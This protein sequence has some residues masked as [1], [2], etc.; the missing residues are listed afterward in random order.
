MELNNI[1]H[2]KP[3]D[4]LD[5]KPDIFIAASGYESR[6]ICIPK[7]FQHLECKKIAFGFDEHLRDLS[8]QDND[9]Y[10]K[11]NGYSLIIQKTHSTPDF[12]K[13]FDEYKQEKIHLLIDISVMTKDW[14]HGLLKYLHKYLRF[15]HFHLRIVY[16]PA[17]YNEPA[18][19]KKNITI[20]KFSFIDEFLDR[21]K[22][23]KKT[24][25]IL[26][27]GNEK[28]ISEK[29]NDLVKADLTF[30][31]YADPTIEKKY[32]EKVFISNHGLIKKT[33][34][35]YLKGYPLIETQE[36]YHIL[37][38]IILPLRQEYHIIIVPQ[39]PKIFSLLSM[40]FQI[41]YPD[42]ELYYPGYKVKQIR[43]RKPYDRFTTL[44]LEFDAE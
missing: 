1:I 24:A 34:I 30:L 11:E 20:K 19:L 14:Y 18:R 32:V 13:I 3:E 33:P 2:T 17:L 26:G 5:F 16:C 28:D 40:V 23:K 41:S 15:E 4:L 9:K 12:S 6:A 21:P 36:I 25:M 42:I 31:M 8:R 10:F 35:R 39:G 29:V 27:L 22:E 7:K 38:D 44:D 43:D 37:L